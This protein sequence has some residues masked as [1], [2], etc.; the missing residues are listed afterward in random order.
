MAASEPG[1]AWPKPLDVG[2]GQVCASFAAT[3]ARRSPAAG[4]RAGGARLQRVL[5]ER[6]AALAPVAKRLALLAEHGE[7]GQD[8]DLLGRS[9][10]HLHCNRLLGSGA[11]TEPLVIG[12]LRRLR[13]GLARAPVSGPR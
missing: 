13:A 12:L 2:N 8:L 3:P 10:V 6:R 1:G 9:F 11:S 4:R 5:G 7:L